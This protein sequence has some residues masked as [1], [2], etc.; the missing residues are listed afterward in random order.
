MKL[1]K[2]LSL[3]ITALLSLSLMTSIDA[4]SHYPVEIINYDYAK[5][6]S[7]EVYE[8]APEKVLAVYQNSV[9]TMLALGLE[10]HLVGVAGLDHEV[11]PELQASLE[12]VNVLSDY[13]PDKE[14]VLMLEPDMILSWYSFFG[15]DHMGDVKEWHDRDVHT[16]MSSN[17]GPLAERTVENEYTDILN[18]GR[19]FDVEDRAE[20]IVEEMREE[21]DKVA[22][23]AKDSEPRTVM[24]IEQSGDSIMLYGENT[25]GGDMVKQLGA[26]LIS[27][28]AS[29][30]GVEDIVSINPDVIFSVYFL[31]EDAVS[32][33]Q[34][35]VEAFKD[36]PALA[37]VAA[38]SNNEVYAIPLGEMYCSGIR[39]ID[40]IK[41]LA[42]GIY[43][44][45]YEANEGN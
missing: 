18:L 16:Y 44:E 35:A 27:T 17:S 39:T 20:E 38:V 32:G 43:P 3:T 7:V 36:N 29:T 37:N 31:E 13:Q 25:L 24:V 5:E 2:T 40:G 10:D 12:K 9:E 22:Q 1:K 41:R 23:H 42:Q 19:I 34:A 6:E 45:L 14:S 8:K 33:E 28:E 4:A 21:I 26:D 30:I 15:E 11:K